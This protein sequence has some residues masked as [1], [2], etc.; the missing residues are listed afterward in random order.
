MRAVS[1][2]GLHRFLCCLN[3]AFDTGFTASE[4]DSVVRQHG[5]ALTLRTSTPAR[6][7]LYH[8]RNTLLRL[9][10]LRRDDARYWINRSEPHVR[11]LLTLPPPRHSAI[12]LPNSVK[13]QFAALVLRNPQCAS[14]FFDL[15]LPVSCGHLTVD[16]FRTSALPVHWVRHSPTEIRL[17]NPVTR[18][19]HRCSSPVSIA[20][21]PYGVRYWARDEL[22]LVDEWA[23]RSIVLPER[24]S[25]VERK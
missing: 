22:H 25:V 18:R 16:E 23:P 4:A 11:I 14:L 7:T 19:S 5:I 8:Y 1:F 3:D 10:A 15:F 13:D 24:N 12:P 17:T 2:G 6:T 21:V 20:A 9:G